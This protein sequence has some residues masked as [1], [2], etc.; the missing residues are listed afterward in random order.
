MN[1]GSPHPQPADP[2]TGQSLVATSTS[3]VWGIKASFIAYLNGMT[4]T[5]SSIT[6]GA[7][8]TSRGRFLF[9]LASSD[10]YDATTNRGTLK[11]AG[12]V[13]FS[14]HFGMLAVGFIEPWITTDDHGTVLSVADIAHYP[15]TT[16]RLPMV[17]LTDATWDDDGRV[18]TWSRVPTTLRSEAVPFFNETYP[19]GEQFDTVDIRIEW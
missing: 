15:D 6:R 19:A 14:A 13:R 17:D 2:A 4:D 5:K 11:F 1:A 8:T 16:V 3:L 12:D 18:R 10:A 7:T 9:P